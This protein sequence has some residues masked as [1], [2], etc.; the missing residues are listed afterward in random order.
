MKFI[1]TLL[2]LLSPLYSLAESPASKEG[3]IE[4]IGDEFGNL[5]TSITQADLDSLALVV[6]DNFTL[7]FGKTTV[8]V[9]LGKTYGDVENGEWISF[10]N[11]E[12]KL[13]LARNLANAAETLNAKVGDAFSIKKILSSPE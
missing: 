9:H 10:V 8:S 6:G 2:C 4:A 11:W 13:R 1:I 12:K 7:T 3:T 5:E